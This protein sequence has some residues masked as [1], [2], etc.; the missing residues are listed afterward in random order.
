MPRVSIVS[1]YYAWYKTRFD[2]LDVLLRLSR[3]RR[4]LLRMRKLVRA[5]R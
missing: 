5:A 3:N 2:I 4:R 1:Q